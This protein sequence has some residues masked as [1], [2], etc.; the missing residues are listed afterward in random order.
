MQRDDRLGLC[1]P[2]HEGVRTLAWE[3]KVVVHRDCGE[4]RPYGQNLKRIRQ[5]N[6]NENIMDT[7][8][9]AHNTVY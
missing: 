3:N 5:I 9:L 1:I 6:H 2:A 7:V 4:D 8:I